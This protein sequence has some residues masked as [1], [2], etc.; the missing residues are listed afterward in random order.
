V[1]AKPLSAEGS[2]DQNSNYGSR[3]FGHTGPSTWNAL[4]YTL[5]SS[6]HCLPTFRLHLEHFCFSHY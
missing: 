1:A 3:A 4:P 5:K 6:S 2:M